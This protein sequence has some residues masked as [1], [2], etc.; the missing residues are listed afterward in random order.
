M[1][2]DPIHQFEIK[3]YFKIGQIGALAIYFTEFSAH[4]MLSVAVICLLTIRPM[5][6]DNWVP[7]ASW[8]WPS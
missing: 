8:R 3:N 7:A 1:N 5:K 6:P 4:M 2:F